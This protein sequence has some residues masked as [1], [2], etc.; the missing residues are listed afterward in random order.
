VMAIL[1]HEQ[2][3]NNFFDLG[4]ALVFWKLV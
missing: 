2:I 4:L 1:V 3:S